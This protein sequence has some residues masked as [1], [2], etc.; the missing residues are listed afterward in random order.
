MD[1]LVVALSSD[2]LTHTWMPTRSTKRQSVF[3]AFRMNDAR[4]TRLRTEIESLLHHYVDVDVVD[5]RVAYGEDWAPQIRDRIKSSSLVLVD[6]TGP[7]KEVLFE[8]GFA[9]NRDCV[10]V[11]HSRSDLDRIPRWITSKDLGIYEGVGLAEIAEKIARRLTDSKV[12]VRRRPAAVP[13]LVTILTAGRLSWEVEVVDKIENLVAE[14]GGTFQLVNADSLQSPEELRKALMAW[15]LIAC[16]DGGGQDYAAHFLLGDIVARPR[17][18]SGPGRGEF[19]QRK[20]LVLV[21]SELDGQTCVADSLRRVSPG[22][23]NVVTTDAWRG[24]VAAGLSRLRD[25]WRNE[26]GAI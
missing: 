12:P 22:I 5:G 25:H 3:V 15:M 13:G 16:V 26:R 23:V 6:V 9:A 18:G 1:K 8:F 20:G 14:R 17:A 21:R 11:V 24:E 10:P 4:S 7:S 19:L 2:E